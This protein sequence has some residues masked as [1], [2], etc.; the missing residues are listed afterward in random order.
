ML[1]SKVKREVVFSI[2]R[3]HE[4]LEY[5]LNLVRL[6]PLRLGLCKAGFK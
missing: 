1:S 3:I 2:S 5:L 6:R 4:K